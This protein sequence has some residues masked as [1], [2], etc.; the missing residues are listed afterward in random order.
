MPS[1]SKEPQKELHGYGNSL[2][3]SSLTQTLEVLT[4]PPLCLQRLMI[5]ILH[6]FIHVYMNYTTR[7]P[8]VL[9][10]KVYMRSCRSSITKQNC[11][12]LA[13]WMRAPKVARGVEP[14]CIW[15]IL[16]FN[17]A[18]PE[19]VFESLGIW[20]ICF[21]C[22]EV[23]GRCALAF[24]TH[25]LRRDCQAQCLQP[26]MSLYVVEPFG[27]FQKF[28]GS[29]ANPRWYLRLLLSRSPQKGPLIDRISHVWWVVCS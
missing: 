15:D 21:W 5:E 2:Q 3:M 23:P 20:G 8:M 16:F 19:L 22:R 4:I 24:R 26:T 1:S 13:A 25:R 11:R 28:R 9:V 29:S 18:A 14:L 27:S 6:V 7:N 10:Y 12:I 17:N